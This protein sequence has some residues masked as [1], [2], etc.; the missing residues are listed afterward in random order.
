MSSTFSIFFASCDTLWNADCKS[1]NEVSEWLS[2]KYIL[3]V[4][5]ERRFSHTSGKEIE[6][7][8]M[9]RLPVNKVTN[10]HYKFSINIAHLVNLDNLDNTIW[11]S[12]SRSYEDFYNISQMPD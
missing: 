7:T 9:I 6:E 8:R 2:H 12:G 1:K 5:T 10:T 3:L 11:P 4:F